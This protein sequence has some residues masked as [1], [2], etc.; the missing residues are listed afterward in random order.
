M[1]TRSLSW[2]YWLVTAGLLGASLVAWPAG[3]AVTTT[4]VA[5]QAVHFVARAHSMRTFPAQTRVAYL[6]LLV[7]GTWPPVR[8]SVIGA[9]G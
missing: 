4:F 8:G 2:W 5:L 3:L 9:L 7:A 6:A 1:R